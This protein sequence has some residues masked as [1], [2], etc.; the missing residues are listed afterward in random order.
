MK[1]STSVGSAEHPNAAQNKQQLHMGYI[2]VPQVVVTLA[3][4]MLF[5]LFTQC[6]TQTRMFDWIS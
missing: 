4:L 5:S 1:I 3:Q 2:L 6:P